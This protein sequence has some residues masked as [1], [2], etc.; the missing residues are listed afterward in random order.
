MMPIVSNYMYIVPLLLLL[1]L[2]LSKCMKKK[3]KIS[4]LLTL[5]RK[6]KQFWD[7]CANRIDDSENL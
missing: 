5:I 4:H 7:T 6:L 2:L 1:L 3:K